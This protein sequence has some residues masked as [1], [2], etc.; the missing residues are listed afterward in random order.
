M[1]TSLL[2]ARTVCILLVPLLLTGCFNLGTPS[3]Q[4][5][6]KYVSSAK[7]EDYDCKAL[8]NEVHDLAEQEQ[9]TAKAQDLRRR[10]SKTQAFWLSIGR[11]DGFEALELSRVRGEKEAAQRAITRKGCQ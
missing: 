11:G 6:G 8:A 1:K 9:V 7:Y 10:R 4:V 3:S 5:P 2:S